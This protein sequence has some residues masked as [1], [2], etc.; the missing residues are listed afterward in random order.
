ME[1]EGLLPHL[2]V[3]SGTPVVLLH[4]F[5]LDARMW[6]AQVAALRRR[7][8][9]LAPD[10][11]GFGANGAES[12]VARPAEAIFQLLSTKALGP[13]H[14]VGLSFG[15]AVAVDF[16]LAHPDAV[17]TLVLVDALLLGE[18]P[19]IDSWSTCMDRA[20]RGDLTGARAAWFAG[21]LFERLRMQPETRQRT[22]E[23]VD[24]Y[25]CGHWRGA[26]TTEWRQPDPKPFLKRVQ[27]P[28]LVL[29]GGADAPTFKAMASAYAQAIPQASLVELEGLGH[30]GP[31]EAPERINALLRDFLEE[32]EPSALPLPSSR[33][34]EF[35]TWGP[36]NAPLGRR[37]WGDARVTAFITSQPFTPLQVEDRVRQE[38]AGQAKYGV[39]YHPLF[40]R[41]NGQL[42]GCCGFRPRVSPPGV[43]ELGFLLRPQYW[44]QGLATEA[45][46][47]AIEHA[48]GVLGASSI[49]AGHH[50]DNVGSARV[51]K[52]LGFQQTHVEHYP[53]TGLDH[54]SYLLRREDVVPP[55]PS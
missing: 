31:M 53:P 4:G 16:L 10:L 19:G 21:E 40:L 14:L 45:A 42:A 35:R 34:L 26:L 28:A 5:G 11:P 32:H 55:S 17:R 51:L 50:P 43:L 6:S 9:V 52:K 46:A 1:S 2:D 29:V 8:R 20:Q 38:I 37:L 48:F 15:G 54:P 22:Q 44:G 36:D 24:A 41:S 18:R 49:F 47:A 12:G 30:M 39:Q 33:R 3:G 27:C 13:V 23:M 7:H 25:R